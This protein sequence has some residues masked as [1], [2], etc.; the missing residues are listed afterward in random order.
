MLWYSRYVTML[1][2]VWT[3]HVQVLRGRVRRDLKTVKKHG[4]SWASRTRTVGA[5]RPDHYSGGV[6]RMA[7]TMRWVHQAARRTLSYQASAP[8]RWTQTIRDE[9][10]ATRGAKSQLEQRFVHIG[11]TRV[12]TNDLLFG[13]R[14]T[15]SYIDKCGAQNSNHI[16]P[17]QF[18]ENAENVALERVRD[19]VER[20]GSVKVNAFNGEF[21]KDKRV[22]KSIDTKNS[23]IY[24]Y[25][26][27]CVW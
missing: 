18:F 23:E 22:N 1:Q 13:E 5:V 20:H 27:L 3:S 21:A 24:R 26:D 16:E 15:R 14:S 9:D 4:K 12:A 17:R 10:R 25:T 2:R 8:R 6:F 11:S 7:A 19:A